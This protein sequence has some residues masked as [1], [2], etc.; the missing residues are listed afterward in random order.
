MLD[1]LTVCALAGFLGGGC[2]MVLGWE[3]ELCM[4]ARSSVGMKTDK[5][6]VCTVR[7]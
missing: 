4:P 6:K 1:R 7:L 5:L 2:T 3:C